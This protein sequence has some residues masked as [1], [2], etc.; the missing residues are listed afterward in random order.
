M[1]ANT[2]AHEMHAHTRFLIW[3]IKRCVFVNRDN[4]LVVQTH[5]PA[6]PVLGSDASVH[7]V[8]QQETRIASPCQT[9]TVLLEFIVSYF[10]NAT[11]FHSN[12]FIPPNIMLVM[13]FYSCSC[14]VLIKMLPRIPYFVLFR[15]N[16]LCNLLLATKLQYQKRDHP[17]SL[18]EG[19]KEAKRGFLPSF[20]PLQM[21]ACGCEEFEIL[22]AIIWLSAG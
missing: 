12:W 20:L 2:N 13:R 14:F 19:L 1:Q 17:S 6:G 3:P 22:L 8:K 16:R 11:W 18:K 15:V 5:K 7:D 4:L 9:A 10:N 21:S